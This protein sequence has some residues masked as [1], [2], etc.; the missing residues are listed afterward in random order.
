MPEEDLAKEEFGARYGASGPQPS[1]VLIKPHAPERIRVPH[2][3]TPL[4][5]RCGTSLTNVSFETSTPLRYA[6]RHLQEA[7]D[8]GTLLRCQLEKMPS[9]RWLFRGS[10][11]LC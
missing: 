1:A 6:I 2:P 7:L 10:R 8:L 4:A 11:R 3:H 9:T 5:A